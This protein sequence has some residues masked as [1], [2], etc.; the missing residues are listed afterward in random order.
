MRNPAPSSMARIAPTW[1]LATA[2]GLTIES[3]RSILSLQ[4]GFHR[5]AELGRALR[6]ANARRLE[7][8]DLVRRGPLPSRDDRA[9]MPHSLSLRSGLAADES[10]HRL[11]HVMLDELG[12]LLLGV[13][14]DLADHDHA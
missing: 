14:A 5:R 13:T 8:L 4:G 7:G 6:H 11:L 1:F 9:G 3:V 10:G 2:S 12:G